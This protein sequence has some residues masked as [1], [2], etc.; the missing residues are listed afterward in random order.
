[1]LLKLVVLIGLAIYFYQADEV[2]LALMAVGGI[3]PG[4]GLVLS[5]ILAILLI[6]KTWYGSAAIVVGLIAFNLIGNAWLDKNSPPSEGP[7]A[8]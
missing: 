8:A 4:I 3:I 7:P 1:M 6:M 5:G 2:G